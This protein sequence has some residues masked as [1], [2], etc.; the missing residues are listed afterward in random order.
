[1]ICTNEEE[2]LNSKENLS[3]LL[4]DHNKLFEKKQ[5]IN[6]KLIDLR[7]NIEVLKRNIQLWEDK[8][9]DSVLVTRFIINF[10]NELFRVMPL[11]HGGFLTEKLLRKALNRGAIIYTKF[12]YEQLKLIKDK[13]YEIFASSSRRL[14]TLEKYDINIKSCIK[15]HIKRITPSVQE[16]MLYS[17]EQIIIN[18]KLLLYL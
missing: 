10:W 11:F 4:E 15:S 16:S 8:G 14:E 1:M 9:K 5:S 17:I 2:Y 13:L 12:T 3:K 6:K 18:N 7:H